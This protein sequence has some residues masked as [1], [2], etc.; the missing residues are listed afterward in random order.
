[1]CHRYSATEY[2]ASGALSWCDTG[3]SI[4]NPT[5]DTMGQMGQHVS[6]NGSRMP[7]PA[8]AVS[9]GEESVRLGEVRELYTSGPSRTVDYPCCEQRGHS[10]AQYTRD[11]LTTR[12]IAVRARQS[13]SM[14][15]GLRFVVCRLGSQ[16]RKLPSVMVE[17]CSWFLGGLFFILKKARTARTY[18]IAL[19]GS[20]ERVVFRSPE[21]CWGS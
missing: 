12:R 16:I 18:G 7:R 11:F 3:V 15:D 14:G 8:S 10:A 20:L 1:M 5:Q 4:Y 19:F 13:S 17:T 21:T 6:Y 2:I 9:T